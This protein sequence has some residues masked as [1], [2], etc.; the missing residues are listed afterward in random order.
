MSVLVVI[1]EK[2]FS[3]SAPEGA[4]F[5]R[6]NYRRAKPPRRPVRKSFQTHHDSSNWP[7]GWFCSGRHLSTETELSHPRKN[8]PMLIFP[9]R[10]SPRQPNAYFPESILLEQHKSPLN[11]TRDAVE[12]TVEFFERSDEELEFRTGG[13][14]EDRKQEI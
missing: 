1:S 14:R 5:L 4:L 10:T 2:T 11:S 12:R 7:P 8:N 9:E 3:L 6:G 13:F